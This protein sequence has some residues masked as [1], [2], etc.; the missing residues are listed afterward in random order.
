[1]YFASLCGG[2][3]CQISDRLNLVVS[4]A[5]GS[6]EIG[7]LGDYVNNSAPLNYG[8]FTRQVQLGQGTISGGITNWFAAVR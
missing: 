1:L 3:V 7:D 8:V 2:T 6:I 5:G 4:L